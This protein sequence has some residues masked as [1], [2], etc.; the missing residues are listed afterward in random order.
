M[1]HADD[2]GRALLVTDALIAAAIVC[3]RLLP[4]RRRTAFQPGG[5]DFRWSSQVC[6]LRR[7]AAFRHRHPVARSAL[8][9]SLP[10]AR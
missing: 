2:Q 10:A 4:A 6:A 3:Y 5:P 7:A 9:R 1:G 8:L